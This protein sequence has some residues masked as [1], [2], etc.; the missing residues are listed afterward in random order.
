MFSRILDI[1]KFVLIIFLIYCF[2]IYFEWNT[3]KIVD[4]N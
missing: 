4:K 1:L 2:Q 3:I